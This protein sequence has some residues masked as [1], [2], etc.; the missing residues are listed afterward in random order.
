MK[1]GAV[2]DKKSF[3]VKQTMRNLSSGLLPDKNNSFFFQF[4]LLNH[5]YISLKN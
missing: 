4:I 1:F 5:L 2:E 3:Y